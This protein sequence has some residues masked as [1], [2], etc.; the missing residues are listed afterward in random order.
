M[1]WFKDYLTNRKQYVRIHF[2]GTNS[3][4]FD[5][6]CGVPQ[7]SVLG[8]LLFLI[9]INDI[10]AA[11]CKL[12]FTLFADDT[13]IFN[14]NSNLQQLI[15]STNE[16]LSKLSLWFKA[17][18]LSL[19]ITKA[20]YMLF[21]NRKKI[22][23]QNMNVII[24]ESII[25]RVKDCK[26]LG[27]IIDENLTWMKHIN[28]VTSKISKN[29]VVM[30]KLSYYLYTDAI[31][32]LYYTLV[33]PYIHYGNIVWANNYPSK[34]SRIVLL[35]KRAVRII[36]KVGYRE[37][38]AEIFKELKLLRVDQINELEIS[39]L[40]FKYNSGQA[41]YRLNQLFKPNHMVHSYETRNRN[42]CYIPYRSSRLGQYSLSFQGPK[43]WNSIDSKTKDTQSVFSFKKC[44][45]QKFLSQQD[46]DSSGKKFTN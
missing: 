34:L 9:Y 32:C 1:L 13:N 5:I 36:A 41:P 27:V 29:I 39:I 3:D 38:T 22:L 40:M 14:K 45:K 17:N 26:F 35:Q 44:I 28:L 18:R 25:T 7:G 10:N 21:S 24:D 20:N 33:Y 42:N 16:E 23:N 31:K 12:S 46:N 4:M 30:H 15:R 11:S 2:Q 19:N 37:S 8:P 43:I 6:T